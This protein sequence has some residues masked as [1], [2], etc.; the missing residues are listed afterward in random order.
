MFLFGGHSAASLADEL[1]VSHEWLELFQIK[2]ARATSHRTHL[3][4]VA[5]TSIGF[6]HLQTLSLVFEFTDAI[7]RPV[8]TPAF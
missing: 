6:C 8:R 4:V 5:G 3:L 7:H 2:M 1:C